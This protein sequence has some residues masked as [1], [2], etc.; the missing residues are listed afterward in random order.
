MLVMVIEFVP[1]T[2]SVGID[3]VTADVAKPFASRDM[4]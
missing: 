3:A 2:I 4:P 1:S